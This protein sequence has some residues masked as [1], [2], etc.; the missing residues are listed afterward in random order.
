MNILR[1]FRH[2]PSAPLARERL[3]ILLSHERGACGAGNLLAILREDIRAAVAKHISLDQR[4]I[5]VQM[6][7]GA[8]ISLLEIEVEIPTACNLAAR[9][10]DLI[11]GDRKAAGC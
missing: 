10:R 9:S 4:N 3:R 5:Q 11:N 7:R 6:G 2:P 1:S 8:R